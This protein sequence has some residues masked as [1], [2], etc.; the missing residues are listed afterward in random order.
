MTRADV[1]YQNQQATATTL[2]DEQQATAAQATQTALQQQQQAVTDA[3]QTLGNDLAAR[4]SDVNALTSF[5][6]QS[7]LA[8]FSTD[9]SVWVMRVKG[10]VR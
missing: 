9:V 10:W 4:T 5:S 2:Q 7:T 8:G 6:E 3:N 1:L